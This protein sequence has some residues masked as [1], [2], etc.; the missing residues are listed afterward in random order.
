MGGKWVSDKFFFSISCENGVA[1]VAISNAEVT[2][3]LDGRLSGGVTRTL[4]NPRVTVS[5]NGKH[6]STVKYFWTDGSSEISST[7]MGGKLFE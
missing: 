1:A 2:V 6:C 3:S 4:L 7:L 5:V